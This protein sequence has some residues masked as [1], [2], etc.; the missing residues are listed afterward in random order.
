M[1][2]RVQ[3]IDAAK[4]I[5]ILL[6]LLGHAPRDI[7]RSD[8]AWID[9]C[10]Y[11]IYTFHM[12]FFFFL[13]GYVF[14]L[15]SDRQGQRG[16]SGFLKGKLRGLLV[17]WALFSVLVYGVIFLINQ[18]PF[19]A[20]LTAGTVL[21]PISFGEYLTQSIAGS[22]PYCTH[23]WY[24]YT[25]FFVQVVVYLLREIGR[26]ITG[27]QQEPL[28]FWIALE[29]L[30]AICYLFLPVELPVAVSVKGYVLYYLFGVICCR[31]RQDRPRQENGEERG[32]FPFW[33]LPGLLLCVVNALAVDMGFLGDPTA[34]TLVS[35]LA[36]FIGA[37]LM[38]ALL[39]WISQKA[40]GSKTLQW[41]GGNS[42]TIYL[43]HQPFACAVLGTVLTMLLPQALPFYL[44]TMAVCI[45]V[46]VAFPILVVRVGN[47]IGLGGFIRLLT[48]GRAND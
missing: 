38:I 31:M 19:A 5:G 29:L 12:H 41:F 37:P 3:W 32:R 46:S 4:G 25:L 28:A 23:V 35:C 47:R 1:R 24:M 14:A 30:A 6:V 18:I 44:L 9:F 43:L 26:K 16:G 40:S 45:G 33:A 2:Q 22:N 34:R 8:Y 42:F 11:F 39:V 13:S 36:V 21:R 17:P 48:G 20:S 15:P 27:R 10:Y 7:M